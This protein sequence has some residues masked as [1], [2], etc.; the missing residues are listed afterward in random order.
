MVSKSHTGV[1]SGLHLAHT[2]PRSG[3]DPALIQQVQ[4]GSD[5]GSTI[6]HYG[7]IDFTLA[8]QHNTDSGA[9]ILNMCP[10]ENLK[11]LRGLRCL[12]ERCH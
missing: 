5:S 1:D 7:S 2:C 4:S 10:Y 6:K 12:E 9:Q 8:K 3:K 11:T